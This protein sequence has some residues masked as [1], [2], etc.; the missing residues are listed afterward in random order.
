MRKITKFAIIY[1]CLISLIGCTKNNEN[2]NNIKSNDKSVTQQ[3]TAVD[4]IYSSMPDVFFNSM[5]SKD[6]NDSIYFAWDN[7]IYRTNKD[8]DMLE[9]L[10]SGKDQGFG[11]IASQYFNGYVYFIYGPHPDISRTA[12]NGIGKIDLN[13]HQ[14]TSIYNTNNYRPSTIRIYNDKMYIESSSLDSD[15]YNCF[16]FDFND[17][18]GTI[19]NPIM[20]DKSI[21][22]TQSNYIKN[23]HPNIFSNTVNSLETLIIGY[24][25]NLVYFVSF[26][27][28]NEVTS[29]NLETGEEKL[30]S[31]RKHY[32]SNYNPG[33]PFDI[34]DGKI[35]SVSIYGVVSFDSNFENMK[36]IIKAENA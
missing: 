1:I 2:D 26:G 6:E 30:Y 3:D 24:N 25:N 20:S 19:K 36:Y 16:I 32:K 29:L 22:F 17:R 31:I 4:S 18:E 12:I 14:F 27:N 9:V 28:E 7:N 23:K 11:I 15:S 13:N 10:F 8:G 21:L 35:Y 5:F 33:T 34:I